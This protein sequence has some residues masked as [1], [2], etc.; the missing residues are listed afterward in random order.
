MGGVLAPAVLS[1]DCSQDVAPALAPLW[2]RH[3]FE[4]ALARCLLRFR[5]RLTT[6]TVRV[7]LRL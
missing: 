3:L 7:S 1:F 2:A 5:T 4:S 6:L